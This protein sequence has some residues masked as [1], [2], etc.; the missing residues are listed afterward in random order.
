MAQN[1]DFVVFLA[2]GETVSAS[3]NTNN[4]VFSGSVRQVATGDGT[5]VQPNGYP[6]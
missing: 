2:A 1:V 6:L 3:S 4:V 5:L